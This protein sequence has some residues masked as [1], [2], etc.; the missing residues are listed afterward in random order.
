MMVFKYRNGKIFKWENGTYSIMQ[1]S[2]ETFVNLN[3]ERA[4]KL[5]AS[6]YGVQ[7]VIE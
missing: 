5:F 4:E 2:K 7:P 6:I 1:G 3:K